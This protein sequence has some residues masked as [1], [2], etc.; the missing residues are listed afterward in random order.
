MRGR[1]AS[2]EAL[3]QA[4]MEGEAGARRWLESNQLAGSSRLA[5]N[6]TVGRWLG[7]RH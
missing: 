1:H 7:N 6:I 5:D 3:Q 2:L 4:A